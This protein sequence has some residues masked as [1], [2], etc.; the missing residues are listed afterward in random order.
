MQAL[1]KNTSNVITFKPAGIT[2]LEH[3]SRKCITIN[4][5]ISIYKAYNEQKTRISEKHTQTH[6]IHHGAKQS[7]WMTFRSLLAF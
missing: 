6:G 4:T 1:I 3:F 7:I 2:C 5:N